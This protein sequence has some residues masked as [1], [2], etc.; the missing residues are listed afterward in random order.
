MIRLLLQKQSDQSLH[1]LSLKL[2]GKQLVFKILKHLPYFPFMG[3]WRVLV[4]QK[5][6]HVIYRLMAGGGGREAQANMEETDRERRPL[7][8]AHNRLLSRK[9][10]LEIRCEICYACS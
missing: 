9:E 1:C 2:F 10:H 8:E 3:M 6:Q 5:E 7:V 4:V